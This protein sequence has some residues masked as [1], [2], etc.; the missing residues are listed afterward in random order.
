M[1]VNLTVCRSAHQELVT[2]I[3]FGKCQIGI[4]GSIL[5]AAFVFWEDRSVATSDDP[6]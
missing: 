1:F 6:R 2:I 5:G 4:D 3:Y